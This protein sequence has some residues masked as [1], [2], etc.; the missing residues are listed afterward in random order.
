MHRYRT[1]FVFI[2][3]HVC[4]HTASI[5]GKCAHTYRTTNASIPY[6]LLHL[7]TGYCTH[8]YHAYTNAVTFFSPSIPFIILNLLFRSLPVRTPTRGRLHSGR[9][10]HL[11]FPQRSCLD[12][13]SRACAYTPN[14]PRKHPNRTTS[15]SR[16]S[17]PCHKYTLTIPCTHVYRTTLT[18][19]T[20]SRKQPNRTTSHIP[21]RATHTS[22]IHA[23]RTK[24]KTKQNK[25]T[26]KQ[27]QHSAPCSRHPPAR[28]GLS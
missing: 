17:I 18:P 4:I 5:P 2:P 3:Y 12:F 8:T 21:Y 11:P 13:L 9:S 1:M 24:T 10:S 26:V 6:H 16:T 27:G 28:I 25:T 19:P 20:I 15:T 7:Y 22:H 14:V 23:T